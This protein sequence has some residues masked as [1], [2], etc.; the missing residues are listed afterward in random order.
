VDAAWKQMNNRFLEFF[1]D[2][3]R[4][5][6]PECPNCVEISFRG[7]V[8]FLMTREPEHIKAVL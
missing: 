1:D 7:T 4:W 3:F 2:V 8:R 6:S 5:A